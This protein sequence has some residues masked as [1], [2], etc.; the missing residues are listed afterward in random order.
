MSKK[1]QEA[2][3]IEKLKEPNYNE[4][5][6]LYC[7]K[8]VAANACGIFKTEFSMKH[9]SS[10]RPMSLELVSKAK[11]I[12]RSAWFEESILENYGLL[13]QLNS[14]HSYCCSIGYTYS[15]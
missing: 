15:N 4:F 9:F 2:A 14:G 13:Y 1:V 5:P 7:S 6:T 3:L 12:N 11:G 8:V 10:P